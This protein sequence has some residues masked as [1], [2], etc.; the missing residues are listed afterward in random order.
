MNAARPAL[1]G[2]GYRAALLNGAILG[3]I[4]YGC[5]EATNMATLRGWTWRIVIVDVTWGTAL[6]A[7]TAVIGTWAGRA[8]AR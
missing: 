6:T 5:Y 4:A 2:G 8:T 3:F 1:A 7:L